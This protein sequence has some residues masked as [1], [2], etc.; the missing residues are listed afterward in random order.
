VGAPG[1]PAAGGPSDTGGGLGPYTILPSPLVYGVWHQK[2]G[3]LGGR[4][5]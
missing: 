1:W 4:I 2:G 3:S 5:L